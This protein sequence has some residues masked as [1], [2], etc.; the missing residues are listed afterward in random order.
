MSEEDYDVVRSSIKDMFSGEKGYIIPPYQRNYAWDDDKATHLWD[1]LSSMIEPSDIDTMSSNLLGAMV[2]LYNR[3]DPSKEVVDGQQRLATLSLIF[4]AIRAYAHK[5][6]DLKSDALRQTI[7]KLVER[8]NKIL[9]IRPNEPRVQLGEIDRKLFKK[10][11]M[12]VDTDYEAFC[13]KQT[14]DFADG[15]KR[16]ADSH[17]LLIKNYKILFQEIEGWLKKNN[18]TAVNMSEADSTSAIHKIEGLLEEL[19]EKNHFAHIQVHKRGLAYK[20]FKTFNSLGQELLQ[21]D[22][23]KS[24]LISKLHPNKAKQDIIRTDWEKIF[25]ERVRDPDNLIYESLLVSQYRINDIGTKKIAIDNLYGIIDEICNNHNSIENYVEELN[26]DAKFLKMM[27]YPDDLPDDEKYDKL[28]SYFYGIHLLNARYIR[29]PI[30]AAFR[31]W[32]GLDDPNFQELV[33]CLLIFFF[34]FRFINEGSIDSIRRISRDITKKIMKDESDF[35]QIIA[36]ILVDSTGGPTPIRRINDKIFK[37]NFQRRMFKLNTKA[38]KYILTSLEVDTRKTKEFGHIRY[39]IEL[40]H[41]LPKSHKK[42][43]VKEF[44]RGAGKNVDDIEKFKNRLGNLTLLTR[45]WCAGAGRKPFSFKKE[46]YKTSDFKINPEF[47]NY[48]DW[49]AVN[50]IDREN[51]LCDRAEVIW[52]LTKYDKYL[53]DAGF[54]NIK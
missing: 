7:D 2:I 23:I 38:A 54:G 50:L 39:N 5:F 53:N 44:F 18:A 6:E 40:E 47:L 13:K 10:L 11:V 49:T 16:L 14:Q 45:K 46:Y 8:L 25:D 32:D 22:L 36:H 42:W 17:D 41:I 31:K 12:N 3:G 1:D 37:E 20:I 26:N 30:L 51:R 29:V 27:D 4:A 34:K 21:A 9:M 48:E 28:K 52:S 15:K 24:H 19:L 35:S 33:E 43:N